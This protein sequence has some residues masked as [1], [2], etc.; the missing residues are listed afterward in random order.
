MSQIM[1]S[2]LL[3]SFVSGVETCCN[4]HKSE[5]EVRYYD[6]DSTYHVCK[7]CMKLERWSKDIELKKSI[8]F[9]NQSQ[10]IR[11]PDNEVVE[12]A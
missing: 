7:S 2:P 6:D 1:N 4:E 11:T 3:H 10:V 9:L 5:F 8:A 12:Y